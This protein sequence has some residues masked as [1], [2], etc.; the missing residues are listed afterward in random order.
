MATTLRNLAIKEGKSVGEAMASWVFDGNTTQET[1]A[2]VLRGIQ[3]GDPVVL[4]NLTTPN[5]SG[6]WADEPTPNSLASDLCIQTDD[7]RLDDLCTLWEDAA[8]QT[9]WDE[10][11]RTCRYHLG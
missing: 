10:I 11:E 2:K 4:D 7:D 1:Y 3:G 9:F 6:E 8:C 5:L